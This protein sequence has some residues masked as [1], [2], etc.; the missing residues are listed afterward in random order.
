MLYTIPAMQGSS[1]SLIFNVYGR[2]TGINF[3]GYTGTQSF[4][5]GIQPQQIKKFLK[6]N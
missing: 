6:G 4:N 2:V 3:A 1:G 5:F